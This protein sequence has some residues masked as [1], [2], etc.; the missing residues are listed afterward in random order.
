M[1]WCCIGHVGTYLPTYWLKMYLFL[2][3]KG[4]MD[5]IPV[6][7]VGNKCDEE[8]GKREVSKKTGEAL[9]VIDWLKSKDIKWNLTNT[10]LKIGLYE[11]FIRQLLILS[12]LC[13]SNSNLLAENFQIMEGDDDDDGAEDLDMVSKMNT[14]QTGQ[15][16]LP[17]SFSFVTCLR[18]LL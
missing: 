11:S 8:S 2:K 13:L 15:Q 14:Y 16:S 9:Q 18:D 6:M 4:T 12:T 3:V 17:G 5:G 1:I 7:L 10:V